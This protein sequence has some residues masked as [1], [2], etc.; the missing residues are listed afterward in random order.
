MAKLLGKADASLVQAA[1]A[2]GMANVPKDLSRIHERL[3]QSHRRT[4]ESL[5]KSFVQTVAAA[6][7]IGSELVKKA[8][9]N[10][11]SVDTGWENDTSDLS[12]DA[13]K[14]K[15]AMVNIGGVMTEVPFEDRNKYSAIPGQGPQDVKDIHTDLPGVFEGYTYKNA[16]GNNLNVTA[17]TVGE[18][19]KKIRDERISLGMFGKNPLNLSREERKAR[20]AELDKI[21]ANLR[22]STVQFKTFENVAT[23]LIE[24]G[25]FNEVATGETKMNFMKALLSK[26]ER[27]EDGSRAIMGFDDKGNMTFAYVDKDGFEITDRDGNPLVMQH[28]D[29]ED[30]LVPESASRPS[31][32][33]NAYGA[34]ES[35]ASGLNFDIT[36]GKI[37]SGINNTVKTKNDFLDAANYRGDGM[38]TSLAEA[39]N[40]VV[41][42]DGEL[43]VADLP[44]I[45]SAE[46]FATLNSLGGVTKDGGYS[47][48]LFVNHKDIWYLD[49]WLGNEDGKITAEDFVSEENYNV[50]KELILDGNNLDISKRI[51]EDHVVNSNKEVYQ[52]IYD[53]Y[54]AKQDFERQKVIQQRNKKVN[55]RVEFDLDLGGGKFDAQKVWADDIR[56][57]Q[58]ELGNLIEQTTIGRMPGE[59]GTPTTGKTVDIFGI[60][61]GYFP[62]EGGYSEVDENNKPIKGKYHK[63]VRDLFNHYSIP[64]TYVG[65]EGGGGTFG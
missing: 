57:K 12:K 16:N 44:S 18:Q 39:L 46:F 1:K 63:S 64:T 38:N 40:G 34:A 30:L 15:T 9:E 42:V 32:N 65:T 58:T 59:V 7:T 24:S 55:P 21:E 56:N 20:K 48:A 50:L 61:V 19:L 10:K 62:K 29:L 26:G 23:T 13:T 2:A 60:K 17:G 8:K 47:D 54:V 33:N 37:R 28:S 36:E 49:D 35:A 41:F 27:L 6:S 43:Q 22:N 5:G 11:K 45:L 31:I 14:A 52:P 4:M 51:L 3:A 53:S 25:Q